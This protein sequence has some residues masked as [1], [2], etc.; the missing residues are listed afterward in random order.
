MVTSIAIYISPPPS[1][2]RR[3]FND[4]EEIIHIL[5]IFKGLEPIN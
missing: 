2:I 5:Q 4:H 3:S 1:Q